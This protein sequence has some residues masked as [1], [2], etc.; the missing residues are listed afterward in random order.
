MIG[1]V[2]KTIT[3]SYAVSIEYWNATDRQTD[4]Q[5]CY[6]TGSVTVYQFPFMPGVFHTPLHS[7]PPVRGIPV[8]ISPPRLVWKN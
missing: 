3:I 6:I 7:T 4:R 1:L 5:N 8:G 2:K